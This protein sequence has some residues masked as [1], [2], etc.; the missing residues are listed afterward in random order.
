VRRDTRSPGGEQPTLLEFSDAKAAL[1]RDLAPMRPRLAANA[2]N[3]PDHL[4]ELKWDGI[5]AVA[6]RDRGQLRVSDRGGGDLLP[7]VTELAELPIPE[8]AVLDGEIVVCDSRG[9]PSYDLLTGRLGPKAAK[10]GRGPVFVAFDLLYEEHQS[11]LGLPLE[12]RRLRLTALGMRGRSVAVPEHLA[13]DGEPFLDV[14]AEYGLEG[15]VAKRRDSIYVPGTRSGDW[16]KCHVT[17]RADVVLGGLVEDERR[18]AI[19][20]L[21]GMFRDDVLAFVGE[22]Y[23]PPFLGRWLDEATRDFTADASPFATPLPLRTGM[24]WLRPRIV[25]IVEHAGEI[26][27]LRDARFRALRFDGR[28][29]DCRVEEPLEMESAPARAG[30]ERPRL[31]VLHSLPF[32]PE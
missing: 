25:A 31:I 30:S 23:V 8:G 16:L 29:D 24:R 14:V 7:L 11:L 13:E 2:F 21:C 22:A 27:E 26:G 32:G 10:R 17:P 3:S 28:L 19:R 12:E 9:R 4:Y 15:I 20:A 1:P 18:G 6:S 5:R